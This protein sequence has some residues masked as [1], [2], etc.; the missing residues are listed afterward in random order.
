MKLIFIRHGDP[1]YEKDSL[2]AKGWKE[3]ELL[4]Q[5]IRLWPE[6]EYFVSPLGRAQDT[7]RVCLEKRGI[8][9]VTLPWLKEFHYP[10]YHPLQNIKH[11]AW[12]FYPEYWTQKMEYYDPELWYKT[13]IM[14][15]AGIEGKY[16]CVQNSFDDFLNRYGYTRQKGYYTV[17]NTGS[18]G[19]KD[20]ILVFFCHF[21]ISAIL[22]AHMINVSPLVLLQNFFMPPSSVTIVCTEERSE[23]KAAFR[24][25][26]MGDTSHLRIAG[27]QVSSSGFFTDVF[28]L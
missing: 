1:D 18:D 3:A 6:A 16:T 2:T 26:V 20:T 4:A 24:T 12:D 15:E 19:N 27:E 8:T 23:G 5:R 11:V 21:G 14:S 28:S 17:N 9:P 22:M 25:Q 7:A 13:D 10:V